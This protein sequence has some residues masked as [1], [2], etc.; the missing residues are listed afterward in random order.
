MD[1]IPGLL[2][3]EDYAALA[4]RLK[5]ISS[6]A[7][8][9]LR[10][11]RSDARLE[12]AL[13]TSLVLQEAF[14]EVCSLF[15][16]G[17]AKP[18]FEVAYALYR[19][20]R[21][22][23][24]SA[25]I[26]R[27]PVATRESVPV[28][29][30][31]AQ[32]LYKEAGTKSIASAG[33]ILRRL[34]ESLHGQDIAVAV[35]TDYLATMASLCIAPSADES[36]LLS[37]AR[38]S[39]DGLF[40]LACY[41]CGV[42]NYSRGA[43]VLLQAIDM[44]S[45]SLAADGLSETEILRECAAY[46]A[47]LGFAYLMLGQ[48]LAA[49]RAATKILEADP[50]V[51]VSPAALAACKWNL[52]LVRMAEGDS[53]DAARLLSVVSSLLV[54]T[55]KLGRL[56]EHVLQVDALLCHLRRGDS[57]DASRLDPMLSGFVPSRV[58]VSR[59]LLESDSVTCPPANE[60]TGSVLLILFRQALIRGDT[61]QVSSLLAVHGPM[62]SAAAPAA[63]A[64]V[65][66]LIQPA[67]GGLES[68]NMASRTSILE[69][70]RSGNVASALN[71]A[72][73]LEYRPP[74]DRAVQMLC[75]HVVAGTPVSPLESL[76]IP[77]VSVDDALTAPMHEPAALVVEDLPEGEGD[78]RRR[79]R[80]RQR[81]NRPAKDTSKPLDQERWMPMKDR[82]YFRR[83]KKRRSKAAAPEPTETVK[84]STDG[85]ILRKK[86]VGKGKGKR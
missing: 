10:G 46:Y 62:L 59:L 73:Q 53:P 85:A 43:E 4:R 64:L 8:D 52:E 41:L 29:L 38:G 80:P 83:G 78:A 24:A 12:Q 6:S 33:D 86:K 30:L 67:S 57:I 81:K 37:F 3:A 84:L 51:S 20:E 48:H 1:D 23:D 76:A 39:H 28:L 58:A 82:S 16:C 18:S 49:R 26:S 5:E 14:D 9:A 22:D 54:A 79:R 19:A 40:N 15:D 50:S 11:V 66:R 31:Q 74:V 71:R 7:D 55:N 75:E 72:R 32:I 36:A 77:V 25:T 34:R 69:D 13:L 35:D 56:Q 44:A 60:V 61:G 27:L 47:Q 63:C 45:R 68:K 21:L 2:A 42:G 70:I 65:R 17:R